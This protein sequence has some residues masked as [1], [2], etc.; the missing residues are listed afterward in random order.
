MATSDADDHNRTYGLDGR[1]GMGSAWTIDWWGA[2]TE[3][4]GLGG[5]DAALGVRLGQQDQKW[6]NFLRYMQVGED[7]NPEVGFLPRAGYRYLE[8]SLFRIVRT[9]GI[10]W[11]R[12]WN[13]HITVREWRGFDWEHQS[14]FFH[15]D[16]EFDFTGGGRLDRSSTSRARR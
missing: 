4:P 10:S 13:P 5:R 8:G 9:P 1:I 12:Q 3:T 6:N 15:F 11:M 2:K 16:P 14:N 7:F